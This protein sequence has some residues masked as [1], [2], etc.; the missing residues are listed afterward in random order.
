[1][2]SIAVALLVVFLMLCVLYY[3]PNN[4]R[5]DVRF[6][7]YVANRL[8]ENTPPSITGGYTFDNGFIEGSKAVA[9]VISLPIRWSV[10]LISQVATFFGLMFGNAIEVMI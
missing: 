1:M 3:I 7:A 8:G 2:K 6:L 9:Y 4:A 10:Y 5:I